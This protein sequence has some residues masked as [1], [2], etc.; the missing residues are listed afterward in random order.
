[1]PLRSSFSNIMRDNKSIQNWH[2]TSWGLWNFFFSV[3]L[4]SKPNAFGHQRSVP[5]LEA[6][7]ST[8]TYPIDLLMPAGDKRRLGQQAQSWKT[9]FAD[10]DVRE[11]SSFVRC[12]SESLWLEEEFFRRTLMTRYLVV[13]WNWRRLTT[14][15]KFVWMYDDSFN[16]DENEINKLSYAFIIY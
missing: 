16:V 4:N 14:K 9:N 10:S 13:Y 3:Q 12:T 8:M 7:P 5:W 1:M 2:V 15:K 6:R 11:N